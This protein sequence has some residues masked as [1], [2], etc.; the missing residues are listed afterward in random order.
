MAKRQAVKPVEE[1]MDSEETSSTIVEEMM[2]DEFAFGSGSEGEEEILPF[3]RK[4]ALRI[5]QQVAEADGAEKELATAVSADEEGRYDFTMDMGSDLEAVHQRFL[6]IVH[7]LQVFKDRR[8]L[9]LKRTDYLSQL[10][11]DLSVYYGYSEW[12]ISMLLELFPP[13]ELIDYLEA[14]EKPRP[15]VLRANGLKTKRGELARSLI[16][17]GVDLDPVGD[18]T[19]EGLHVYKS[20]VPLGATPEYLLGH[21]L[22]QDAAS[23][24]P[25]LALGAKPG[26]RVLDM[27]AAPGGKTTHIG[28]FMKNEGTLLA[29]DVN[30]D[31]IPSLLANIQ[32]LGICNCVVTNYDGRNL[33]KIIGATLDRVLLDAPCTG[34]GTVSRDPTAKVSKDGTDVLRMA[35]LQKEL[36]LAAID[37]LKVGG[38]LVYSTC[39]IT[40]PEN[41]AIV[42]YLLKYRHVKIQPLPEAIQFGRPGLVNFRGKRFDASIKHAR[43]VYPHTHNMLGFFVCLLV[44]TEPGVKGKRPDGSG[45]PKATVP[46]MKRK[47]RPMPNKR[48]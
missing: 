46:K 5:A 19:R 14:N 9:H 26:E 30:E 43:R 2:D 18:W 11:L 34:L 29:N 1:V 36:A 22:I 35:H 6:K 4:A 38:S 37:M 25:V 23:F 27:A 3:E 45:P 13:V 33:T 41:E 28:Q 32:R 12:H 47:P 48:I 16:A 39:S 10:A 15:L 42:D 40:V 24:L 20:Q 31:R 7:T 17:R 21:Y 44:K 8:A